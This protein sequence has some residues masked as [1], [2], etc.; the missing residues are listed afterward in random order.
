MKEISG[1]ACIKGKE[2]VMKTKM[3]LITILFT[4]FLALPAMDAVNVYAWDDCPK[5]LANDEYPGSCPRY[6]DTDENGICDHSEP[7]PEDR[8][9]NQSPVEIVDQKQSENTITH[10]DSKEFET[11]SKNT[12]LLSIL[13]PLIAILGYAGIY[14]I[15]QSKIS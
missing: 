15:K 11:T 5:G 3:L 10:N 4:A 7:A 8:I 13:V 2:I 14:K 6:I 1:I 12:V 9:E